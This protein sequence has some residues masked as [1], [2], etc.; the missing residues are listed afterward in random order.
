MRP[1]FRLLLFL[2]IFTLLLP[3]FD[4]PKGR[5]AGQQ[6]T[7]TLWKG[8][9]HLIHKHS[10]TES[11]VT[12][13]WSRTA[14]LDFSVNNR[15]KI[16]PQKRALYHSLTAEWRLKTRLAASMRHGKSPVD[17][18]QI[19]LA[20]VQMSVKTCAPELSAEVRGLADNTLRLSVA[21]TP[22]V[23][24]QLAGAGESRGNL[25]LIMRGEFPYDYNETS[26]GPPEVD[27]PQM[28]TSSSNPL[29]GVGAILNPPTTP[30]KMKVTMKRKSL[31]L[32]YQPLATDMARSTPSGKTWSPDPDRPNYA[33]DG[34]LRIIHGNSRTQVMVDGKDA[35]A[36]F[37]ITRFIT[38]SIQRIDSNGKRI[39]KIRTAP[40]KLDTKAVGGLWIDVPGQRLNTPPNK[41]PEERYM[42]EFLVGVERFP[43]F[44]GLYFIVVI[45]TKPNWYRVRMYPEKIISVK[46]WCAIK[47]RKSPYQNEDDSGTP[48]DTDWQRVR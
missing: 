33:T 10:G 16:D 6:T 34:G 5:A 1:A 43:E 18:Q 7:V 9:A 28:Q 14:D 23:M 27:V 44:G 48:L 38:D 26:F 42:L 15:R 30:A 2:L 25:A 37:E 13:T 29:P 46:E 24:Y 17:E 31:K 21:A 41:W 32:E 40:W 4:E 36:S 47:A 22:E 12:V 45:D 35:T 19:D 39:G 3:P 8:E 20:E 11:E